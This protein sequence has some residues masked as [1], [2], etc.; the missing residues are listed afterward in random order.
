MMHAW[1]SLLAL[2]VASLTAASIIIRITRRL[3]TMS[4][5]LQQLTAEVSMQAEKIDALQASIDA[6]QELIAASL[7]AL[8]AALVEAADP[9]ALQD[10]LDAIKANNGQIDDAAADVA[11]TPLSGSDAG[12]A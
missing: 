5:L 2:W 3:D 8:E 12:P 4:E 1:L 10:L 9:T 11:A 7:A 6:K